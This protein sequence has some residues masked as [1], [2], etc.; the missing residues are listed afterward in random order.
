MSTNQVLV[1]DDEESVRLTLRRALEEEGLSV[2]TAYR[3]H[4]QNGPGS[5]EYPADADLG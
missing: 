1:I 5:A 2:R 3:E 4:I